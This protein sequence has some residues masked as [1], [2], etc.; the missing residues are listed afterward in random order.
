MKSGTFEICKCSVA[1]SMP[2]DVCN[3]SI[4][5][6]ICILQVNVSYSNCNVI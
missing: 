5:C 4:V 3:V 6:I 1:F 2:Y